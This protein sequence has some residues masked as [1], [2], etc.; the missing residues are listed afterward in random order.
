MS[1]P[2]TWVT[3]AG[4]LGVYPAEIP[5]SFKVV[6]IAEFPYAITDY[7]LISGSL[8]EGLSFRDDGLIYGTPSTTSVNITYTFVIR[9]NASD[10]TN[11]GIKDRTF[12]MEVSGEATPTLI[13]SADITVYDSLW[14][15]QQISYNN[16][17][18]NNP[19]NLR[20]I[21]G[22][23][24]PGL[25]INE[26]GYIRGYPAPPITTVN[27]PKIETTVTGVS[28]VN[29][30][31]TAVSTE[32]FS[33]NRPITFSTPIANIEA[34]ETY[35]IKEIINDSQFTITAV[36]NGIIFLITSTLSSFSDV[37]LSPISIGQ[38]TKRQYN[39]VIDLT[40]PAGNDRQNYT[41]TVVNQNLSTSQGG[42]G[43]TPGTRIPT[44]YNTRPP[45]F[46]IQNDVVNYGYY[47]L[48][49]AG[50]VDL[51]VTYNPSFPA[52]IGQFQSNNYF[53]FHILGH[54][55]DNSEI[56]YEFFNL[57][58]WMTADTI[59]GWIYGDPVV[60]TG[61]IE[62]YNFSVRVYKTIGSLEITSSTFNFSFRIANSIE[63]NISWLSDSNLGTLYNA[64][65]SYKNVLA[66]SDVSLVYEVWS[67]NLPPNLYMTSQ[68]EIR[69]VAAY[70][71]VNTYQ[72]KNTEQE[73]T[74]T[75]KAYNTT[76]LKE[77]TANLFEQGNR[78][79][80]SDLRNTDFI[81]VGAVVVDATD[82][83]GG[84]YYFI[85]EIGTTD[86]ES[87]GATAVNAGNLVYGTTYIISDPG[88][89]DFTL[90]GASTN[91]I[92]TRFIASW[93]NPSDPDPTTG[94][95]KVLM[96]E[97]F[98]NYNG[99]GTGT[100]LEKMFYAN[101]PGTGAGT[102]ETYLVYSNKTFT[103]TILQVYDEPTDNLY[104]KCNPNIADRNILKTLLNNQ[105]IIPNDYLYRQS[106]PYFGKARDISYTHAYGIH[107]SDIEDYIIAVQKNHYWKNIT[108]GQLST[109]V[110]KDENGTIIY[111]VVYS[112]VIDNLQK[113]NPQKGV[114]YRYSTSIS[115]TIYWPRFID[116]NL[117]P[118]Y[119]SSQD[120]Y[121]SYIFAQDAVLISE[122]REFNLLTQTGIPIMLNGGV[123]TFYTSL[124]PEYKRLLYPNSLDNMRKRVE[125]T[126][127][128]NYNFRLLPLW[129][130]SQQEDGNTL[131]F[132]PAW[133]IAYTKP[134]ELI[135]TTASQT[136]QGIP[137]II[138]P[139]VQVASTEG[140]VVG[141]PIVFTG[142]T[143][144]NI[145]NGQIYYVKQL[146]PFNQVELTTSITYDSNG[147][148]IPGNTYPLYNE[149][150]TNTGP[151]TVVFDPESYAK[152]IKERIEKDWPY[153]LNEI[154][155]DIDR[156]TVDKVLTYDFDAKLNPGA[157]LDYPSATP[158][159]NPEDSENF[160]VLF[161][162]RNIL[163][164]IGSDEIT[165]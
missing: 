1:H 106:D 54:D 102:A 46:D 145:I 98:A 110:A 20:I 51:G 29:N 69:G 61:D 76:I 158:T 71:P 56:T 65:I 80:I 41:I 126:L 63:G 131:G 78:Y 161:P 157:W 142:N 149:N 151:M 111:E 139:R 121:T 37:T 150:D 115:E 28:S 42:P 119:S 33:I 53:S 45:I 101:G 103:L 19:V 147:N 24:P 132:T 160:Y 105:T 43:F 116:L 120:I 3:S 77:V 59:T 47:V 31:I 8:P 36:P 153:K 73:F 96:P 163:S 5:L 144:G 72:E 104:I 108:L 50:S 70:Q 155:F 64:S 62:E 94:T 35:Y 12:S 52:Y 84:Q 79:W 83:K 6:A 88:T 125:Q 15:T 55:F 127:G 4:L 48:P 135:T 44:I 11:T 90:A 162:R 143:F 74:F 95:G 91:A 128:A 117:G 66:E 152:I 10:G 164:K 16:P 86:Y 140:F 159:P 18:V 93:A 23:L 122:L 99:S 154:D 13:P 30:Y 34:N 112:N 49:P 87:L 124:T 60:T 40:S 26:S 89:S 97:F 82:I 39:F 141:R 2:V 58:S 81:A 85:N 67:G 9:V 17:L 25:E 165:G 107:S 138:P 137:E 14:Y 21:Q 146:L 156:F 109:A 133:V 7:I 38:P 32:G 75:V 113:Y 129:M 136:Y 148:P 57:P 68:G 100:V 22:T 130:T 92:G 114:D 123:P 118:W 134:A 27:L